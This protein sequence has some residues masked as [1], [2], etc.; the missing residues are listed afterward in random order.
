MSYYQQTPNYFRNPYPYWGETGDRGGALPGWGMLWRAAGPARLA[1]GADPATTTSVFSVLAQKHPELLQSLAQQV[2]PP[3]PAEKPFKERPWWLLP[4][5]V[6][7]LLGTVAFV[8]DK[9]GWI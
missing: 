8:A 5:G 1:I 3:P 2:P 9:K 4:I 7:V 6:S